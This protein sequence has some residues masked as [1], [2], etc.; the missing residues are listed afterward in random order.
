MRS[1]IKWHRTGIVV[2]AR[3]LP[4][5]RLPFLLAED[6]LERSLSQERQSTALLAVTIELGIRPA[7]NA[8][9]HQGGAFPICIVVTCQLLILK[10]RDDLD[11]DVARL[12]APAARIGATRVRTRPAVLD[13]DREVSWVNLAGATICVDQRTSG[14]ENSIVFQNHSHHQLSIVVQVEGQPIPTRIHDRLEIA[15]LV[16]EPGNAACRM[17]DPVDG[18]GALGSHSRARVVV[19]VTPYFV[20]MVPIIVMGHWSL[21]FGKGDIQRVVLHLPE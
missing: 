18:Q 20:F 6:S 9:A 19:G 10:D 11:V 3:T 16:V 14:Q 13:G 1:I 4:H 5:P 12:N 15:P 2:L 8:S 21:A 7:S 17:G